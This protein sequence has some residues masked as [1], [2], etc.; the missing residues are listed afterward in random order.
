MPRNALIESSPRP[1]GEVAEQQI[2]DALFKGQ[3]ISAIKIHRQETGAG[4]KESKEFIEVLERQLRSESPEKFAARPS[5][6][7]VAAV[8]A[9]GLA[10]AAVVTTAL[11]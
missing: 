8:L 10:L 1:I 7:C 11:T 6:G 5:R 2:Y 4:L 9:L 3:V